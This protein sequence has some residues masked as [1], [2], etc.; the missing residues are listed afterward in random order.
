MQL[1]ELR[2]KGTTFSTTNQ[3]FVCFYL[4]YFAVDIFTNH[5]FTS[6]SEN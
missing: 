6:N 3:Y 2:Y 1:E 5:L 4:L